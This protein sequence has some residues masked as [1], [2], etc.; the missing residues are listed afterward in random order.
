VTVREIC[1]KLKDAV[2]KREVYAFHYGD[3]LGLL[4]SAQPAAALDALCGGDAA[5]VNLSLKILEDASQLRSKPLDALSAN[6]LLAWCEEKPGSRC[7]VVATGITAF[8][9]SAEDGRYELTETARRLLELGPDRV[10][11][12]RKYLEQFGVVEWTTSYSAVVES[13]VKLLDQFSDYQDPRIR[14]FVAKEK[15][16]LATVV[17]VEPQGETQA[18]KLQDERFE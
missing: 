13:S 3:L 8:Q 12:L 11:V 5:D 16:R 6:D 1:R 9:V 4:L 15:A 2:S 18:R 7:P 14:E 10:A 17:I